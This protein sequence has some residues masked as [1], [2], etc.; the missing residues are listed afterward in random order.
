MQNLRTI[1]FNMESWGNS[2]GFGP[3]LGLNK[4]TLMGKEVTFSPVWTGLSAAPDKIF[5]SFNESI[6]S[7]VDPLYTVV[8]FSAGRGMI[9]E[10]IRL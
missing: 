5:Y 1:V 3:G 10:H 4:C 7:V 2:Q 9:L 6:H 8:S